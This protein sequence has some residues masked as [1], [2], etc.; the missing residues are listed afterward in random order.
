M[1]LE[2]GES[3]AFIY[4]TL[5]YSNRTHFCMWLVSYIFMGIRFRIDHPRNSAQPERSFP[6]ALPDDCTVRMKLQGQEP[7]QCVHF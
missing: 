6:K 7:T 3:A 4:T 2:F 1:Q 5:R